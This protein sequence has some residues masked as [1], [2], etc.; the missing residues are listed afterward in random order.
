MKPKEDLGKSDTKMEFDSSSFDDDII[1]ATPPPEA[2]EFKKTLSKTKPKLTD[3]E[4]LQKLPKTN[5]FEI[6]DA[7]D[8]VPPPKV[9]KEQSFLSHMDNLSKK[10]KVSNAGD[11]SPDIIETSQ[12]ERIE[13]VTESRS[14]SNSVSDNISSTSVNETKG[15]KKLITSY[16]QKSFKSS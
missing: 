2:N 10:I 6:L 12:D 4:L 7:I 14:L 13:S 3:E 8:G 15:A 9:S 11:E 1:P 5:I 16:F